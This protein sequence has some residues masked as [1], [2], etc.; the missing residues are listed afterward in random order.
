MK[1]FLKKAEGFTLVELIVVIAILGI[2]TA[3]AVPAYSGYI[4]KANESADITQLD[5]VLTAS[6][7]AL[8]EKGS[9][10]KVVV[11]TE[12]AADGDVVAVSAFVGGTPGTPAQGETPAVP[13][14][15]GTEY[16][17]VAASATSEAPEAL[18]FDLYFGQNLPTLKSKTYIGGA[19]WSSLGANANEW[20]KK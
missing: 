20:V 12:G 3:I 19:V 4:T 9:V 10:T 8:A 2:L 17:L 18:D 13:A 5:A 15:D 16:K 7:A 6:Q 14:S 11:T 1:K